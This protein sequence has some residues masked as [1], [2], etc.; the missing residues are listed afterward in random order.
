MTSAAPD[1][2]RW[3]QQK[4][5]GLHSRVLYSMTVVRPHRERSSIACSTAELRNHKNSISFCILGRC[6]RLTLV[7]VCQESGRDPVSLLLLRS[8]LAICNYQE[9]HCYTMHTCTPKTHVTR[10]MCKHE[11]CLHK[12]GMNGVR[13]AARFM[14]CWQKN[15][16]GTTLAE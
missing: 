7:H 12:H 14:G 10:C 16:V 6:Y 1:M 5:S 3:E 15:D 2:G 8:R 9:G 4:K 11:V 13:S